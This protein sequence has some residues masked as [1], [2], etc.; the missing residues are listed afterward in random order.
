MNNDVIQK[1]K[2]KLTM[3][4]TLL[5]PYEQYLPHIISHLKANAA[6]VLISRKKLA[7]TCFREKWLSD[8]GRASTLSG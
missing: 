8:L 7:L 4:Y 6:K 1:L 2:K 5:T 3:I